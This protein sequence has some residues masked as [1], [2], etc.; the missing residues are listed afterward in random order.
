MSSNNNPNKKPLFNNI[1]EYQCEVER[2][3]EIIN[4]QSKIINQQEIIINQFR[5]TKT[6]LR[7]VGFTPITGA[8]SYPKTFPMYGSPL[9]ELMRRNTPMIMELGETFEQRMES[10]MAGFKGIGKTESNNSINYISSDV[11]YRGETPI[12]ELLLKQSKGQFL[13]KEEKDR[14]TLHAESVRKKRKK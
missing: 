4:N 14:C 11:D 12:K 5:D 3:E 10:L 2:L 6:G 1:E 9:Y 8:M 13:T 7:K